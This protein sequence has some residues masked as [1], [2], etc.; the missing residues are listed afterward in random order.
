MEWSIISWVRRGGSQ[1][2]EDPNAFDHITLVRM[3]GKPVITHLRMD[4][5]LDNTGQVPL[6]TDYQNP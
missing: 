6:K 2:P 3:A 1:R 4:G 5:V